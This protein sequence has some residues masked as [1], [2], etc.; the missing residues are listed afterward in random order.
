MAGKTYAIP[1]FAVSAIA[2]ENGRKVR[3]MASKPNPPT[4]ELN[5]R[6][7]PHAPEALRLIARKIRIMQPEE[8]DA[9]DKMAKTFETWRQAYV[10]R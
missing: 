6:D 1:A 7:H 9:L 8:A 10:R 2:N 5:A 3:H 4:I